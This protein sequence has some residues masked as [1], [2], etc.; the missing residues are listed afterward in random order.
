MKEKG[1]ANILKKQ[2]NVQL[3]AGPL[4]ALNATETNPLGYQLKF[5]IECVIK[6]TQLSPI[7]FYRDE[8]QVNA[9]PLDCS[10]SLTENAFNSYQIV[11]YSLKGPE[12]EII[13]SYET[14]YNHK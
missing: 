13:N 9:L 12:I 8:F 6:P 10:S 14:I 5:C 11:E 4:Y 2:Q 1:C 7:A 3:G